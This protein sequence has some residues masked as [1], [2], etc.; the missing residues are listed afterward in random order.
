MVGLLHGAAV[1]ARAQVRGNQSVVAAAHVA[2][3]FAGFLL[4]YGVLGHAGLPREF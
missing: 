4:G 2:L 3:G 1:G